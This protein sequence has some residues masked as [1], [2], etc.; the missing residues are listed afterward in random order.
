[1]KN[2]GARRTLRPADSHPRLQSVSA[3]FLRLRSRGC[4]PGPPSSPWSPPPTPGHALQNTSEE[5]TLTRACPLDLLLGAPTP[6]PLSEE[7]GCAVSRPQAGPKPKAAGWS[8]WASASP[9]VLP[10]VPTH[11]A[12]R[13]PA[14]QPASDVCS[15]LIVS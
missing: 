2:T 8:L 1:M 3:S 11:P 7:M 5:M 12:G 6:C 10:T 15:Q 14:A 4:R 9:T 13:T